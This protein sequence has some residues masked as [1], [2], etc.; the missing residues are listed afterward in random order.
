MPLAT[1]IAL[2]RESKVNDR[3]KDPALLGKRLTV[4]QYRVNSRDY[5]QEFGN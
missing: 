4:H 5:G 1:G 2:H 3:L